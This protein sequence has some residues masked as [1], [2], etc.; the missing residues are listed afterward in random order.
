MIWSV[1][2]SKIR[3]IGEYTTCDGPWG[4][5]Y[6][7]FLTREECFEA[8]FYARGRDKVLSELKCRLQHELRTGLCHSTELASRIL[9]PAQLE[10]H[11]LFNLVPKRPAGI[12]ARLR[13]FISPGVELHFTHEVRKEL[14]HA[15]RD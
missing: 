9:W 6:F 4:D 2:I 15:I 1:P 11:P 12:I 3:I 13:Q 7:V 5:D 14:N 10:G 8:S